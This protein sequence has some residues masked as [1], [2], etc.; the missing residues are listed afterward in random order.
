MSQRRPGA[1]RPPPGRARRQ[2][3]WMWVVTGLIVAGVVGFIVLASRGGGGDGTASAATIECSRN[4][5]FNHHVHANLRIYVNGQNVPVPANVGIR[6]DCLYWLHT[7][8]SSGTIH[9]EAPRT[10]NYTLGQFFQV[11]EKTLSPT[12]LMGYQ[13]DDQH[14]IK[15]FVDGQE[16]TGD[17]AQIPLK[18]RSVITL[19]YGPPFMPPHTHQFQPNE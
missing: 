7:H 16:Y 10:A 11:W 6:T 12:E 14:Q 4:E 15:A 9:V 3:P 13:V 1:R 17:P 18:G 2:F 8:D 19:Q 5:Y